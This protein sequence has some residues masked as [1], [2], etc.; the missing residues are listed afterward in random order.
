M[1][2]VRQLSNPRCMDVFVEEMQNLFI[3]Q[4]FDL[5]WTRQGEC[6]S[7]DEYL[8]MISQ[9]MSFRLMRFDPV[10]MVISF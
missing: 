5:Y 7:Q 10:L 1:D 9:S 4:S 6:P 3:G 2:Q 8:E